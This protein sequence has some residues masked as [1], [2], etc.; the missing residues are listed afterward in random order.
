MFKKICAVIIIFC[1]IFEQVGF[2]QIA[3]ELGIPAYLSN[4]TPVSNRFRPVQ[5]RS[6]AFDPVLQNFDL[7]LDTGD[8]EKIQPADLSSAA[9]KLMEYFRVGLV[10]PN[11]LFWVNLRPDSPDDI[12]DTY[13]ARTDMGKVLL[14]ADLQ[15]KKDLARLTNPDTQEGS[16]YWNKL[17]AKAQSIFGSNDIE[18]PTFTRPWIVPGEII[19]RETPDGAFIYKA[20]L[21][22][23]LEQDYLSRPATNLGAGKDAQGY[24]FDDPRLKEI[25][26]YSSQL[27]RETVIPRLTRE[28]NASKN[29]S[30]LRQVYY[31]LILA[32]W[33][34]RKMQGTKDPLSEKID[35]KDLA[36]LTSKAAWNKDTYYQA[37]KRSFQQGEYNKAEEVQSPG[38]LIVRNYFSGGM[39]FDGGSMSAM[40]IIR[41]RAEDVAVQLQ[42][43]LVAIRVRLSGAE[44]SKISSGQ[45]DL[46]IYFNK[47]RFAQ[48]MGDKSSSYY[49]ERAIAT[50]QQ[51]DGQLQQ[52]TGKQFKNLNQEQLDEL[53]Q[54]YRDFMLSH[55][56]AG[57]MPVLNHFRPF[58]I[59]EQFNERFSKETYFKSDLIYWE[60]SLS[61]VPIL[62][63]FDPVKKV[64]YS[65]PVD[66][67]AYTEQDV[68]K[69][70]L[71]DLLAVIRRLPQ[72]EQDRLQL[73]V[74][75]GNGRGLRGFFIVEEDRLIDFKGYT[76]LDIDVSRGHR[77]AGADPTMSMSRDAAL[78]E[79]DALLKIG[80]VDAEFQ[81]IVTIDGITY[82]QLRR[83]GRIGEYGC[84]LLRMYDIKNVKDLSQIRSPHATFKEHY[85]YAGKNFGRQLAKIHSML[86]FNGLVDKLLN[87]IQSFWHA[88]NVDPFGNL[89]DIEG[90]TYKQHTGHEFDPSNEQD[91]AR[92][93]AWIAEDIRRF[94]VGMDM[95]DPTH[96]I[97]DK[98][99]IGNVDNTEYKRAFLEGFLETYAGDSGI[100]LQDQDLVFEGYGATAQL[101]LKTLGVSDFKGYE[102]A[103]Q[104]YL[105]PGRLADVMVEKIV[106]RY[107]GADMKDG[108]VEF[109]L[110]LSAIYK[111]SPDRQ[112]DIAQYEGQQAALK[113]YIL[114]QLNIYSTQLKL[115]RAGTFQVQKIEVKYKEN[116]WYKDIFK[117]MVTLATGESFN[118]CLAILKPNDLGGDNRPVSQSK[119]AIDMFIAEA[120]RKIDYAARAPGLGLPAD[121]VPAMYDT[122]VT[123]SGPLYY[124]LQEWFDETI[125][126]IMMK[127]ALT[128]TELEGIAQA[129]M[130]M[131]NVYD[132]YVQDPRGNNIMMR[133]TESLAL[134]DIGVMRH[135]RNAAAPG[136][137]LD[138]KDIIHNLFSYY[139]QHN[140]RPGFRFDKTTP[141]LNTSDIE[142]AILSGIQKGLGPEKWEKFIN[143]A[144]ASVEL[145][146]FERRAIESFVQKSKQPAAKADGG[147]GK[148]T[149]A[150]SP[151]DK[152]NGNDY[153]IR[154]AGFEIYRSMVETFKE[155]MSISPELSAFGAMI[156]NGSL[157]TSPIS[158]LATAGERGRSGSILAGSSSNKQSWDNATTDPAAHDP[159]SFRYIVHGMQPPHIR[160]MRDLMI[161]KEGLLMDKS[162]EI[163][164]TTEPERVSEKTVIST[165]YVDQDH[166][167]TWGG[168]GFI[169]KVPGRNI[170]ST[171]YSDAGTPFFEGA[172]WVKKQ[173]DS[174]N[175]MTPEELM[176]MTSSHNYNE[177]VITGT[178]PDDT[179]SK[180]EIIGVFF[181]RLPNG[182]LLANSE[183]ATDEDMMISARLR[184]RAGKNGW[185]VVYIDEP[186]FE[187]QNRAPEFMDHSDDTKQSFAIAVNKDGKRYIVEGDSGG[188]IRGR[189]NEFGGAVSNPM[190]EEQFNIFLKEITSYVQ[191]NRFE[192]IRRTISSGTGEP[193]TVSSIYDRLMKRG[194]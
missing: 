56:L 135:L 189:V 24:N 175:I 181:K 163:D 38:G 54:L 37:Y 138:E 121:L 171:H 4:I 91:R 14:E 23:C 31:S 187:F 162:R 182:V 42:D 81:D 186:V 184:A 71:K 145:Q 168:Y 156:F 32:Q 125:S 97:V 150:V 16:R 18:I 128:Y 53:W 66:T 39:I 178:H 60:Q 5:L 19:V 161:M 134:V 191:T 193:E 146:Y 30:S 112:E 59:L 41:S 67:T 190:N 8:A 2:A 124:Y 107:S 120:E 11:S 105:L 165:S 50:E 40:Q 102:A 12:I 28:V 100:T 86:I 73:R 48:A 110:D 101:V 183:G 136:Y 111:G 137:S 170:I 167:D 152:F 3:P 63:F 158:V 96:S 61:G 153:D 70:D 154:Q 164:L 114:K 46:D 188:S 10:L 126:G 176:L 75:W 160:L 64:S 49:E 133:T 34:K 109:Q 65:V 123:R 140:L 57:R 169:L 87:Y 108:G 77:H 151:V 43:R 83:E 174:Q 99:F 29:Y 139:D 44:W 62:I 7:L 132:E 80:A 15:L 6:L 82:G 116:G 177:V 27:I 143:A 78:F 76:F 90:Y 85:Y 180:V 84:P 149:D 68:F 52:L 25:N 118:L 88:G 148:P 104:R 36:G 159:G 45:S 127:R 115:G 47:I 89:I 98:G 194:L 51:L 103:R 95:D 94:L 157:H 74:G 130:T 26:E 106:G 9:D 93:R 35:T 141:I 20:T 142:K 1:F 33:F 172:E 155:K 129:W 69:H 122:G 79:V 185:P 17:Y 13:L 72:E 22:V 58:P 113:E 179:S 55:I 117:V 21:K 119:N 92:V 173:I 131:A 166:R 144:L 192:I 147:K